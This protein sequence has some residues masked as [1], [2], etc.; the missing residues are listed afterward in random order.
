MNRL[1][2]WDVDTQADFMLPEGKLY[3]PGAE[4][5]IPNL[6]R[7][8]SFAVQ[9]SIQIVASTDAHLETDPEFIEYPPHCLVGT[10]GQNKIECTVL[11]NQVT[12]PNR[13]I[14][15]PENLSSFAQI[16]IEK[17]ATDVF[18]NPNV[19]EFLARIGRDREIILYGVVTEICVEQA[20]RGL[21]QRGRHVHLVTDAIRSMDAAKADE[22]ILL[23]RRNGGLLLATEEILS[24]ILQPTR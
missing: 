18:T 9:H 19:D 16:I 24:G 11:R 22:T 2:F 10:A 6:L 17:Q 7:L 23:V 4:Q 5:I 3:V 12:I 21:I 1:L 15:L 8:T 14:D 20:A 13:K